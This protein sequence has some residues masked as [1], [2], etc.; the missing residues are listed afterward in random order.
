MTNAAGPRVRRIM[1]PAPIACRVRSADQHP[2]LTTASQVR[3]QKTMIAATRA[4]GT[5]NVFCGSANRYARINFGARR[6]ASAAIC[7]TRGRDLSVMC[8]HNTYLASAR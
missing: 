4:G 1:S 8:Q 6:G 3:P 7:V 2:R 5:R